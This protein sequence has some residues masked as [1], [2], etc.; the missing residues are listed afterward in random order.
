MSYSLFFQPPK[1]SAT[2]PTE[3]SVKERFSHPNFTN[4]N[5]LRTQHTQS[6]HGSFR[7]ALSEYGR[8]YNLSYASMAEQPGRRSTDIYRRNALQTPA[9]SNSTSH[10]QHFH[11]P[12]GSRFTLEPTRIIPAGLSR[13]SRSLNTG[14]RDALIAQYSS[15]SSGRLASSV[16]NGGGG[17][18]CSD[19]SRHSTLVVES[20]AASLEARRLASFPSGQPPDAS[21][22][23]AIERY[24][25][26]APASTA[27]MTAELMRERR[28]RLREQ[29]VLA[30]SS[31]ESVE[32]LSIDTSIGSHNELDGVAGGIGRVSPVVHFF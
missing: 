12:Q 11:I 18:G 25:W 29:G 28:Q 7:H 5:T 2:L 16:S 19:S 10:L 13:N 27:V 3:S 4:P 21:S 9:T 14:L 22:V 20:E 23:P 1:V 24:D 31:D 8:F 32:D 15:V 30:A 17:G 26:P 6:L